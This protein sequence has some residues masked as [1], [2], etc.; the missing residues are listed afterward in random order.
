MEDYVLTDLEK[1]RLLIVVTST[2]GNGDCP[3]NG[4]VKRDSLI[5]LEILKIL[6]WEYHIEYYR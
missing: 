4:E 2:F 3:A 1:E 5:T 6:P